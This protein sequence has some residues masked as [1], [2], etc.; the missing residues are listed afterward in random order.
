[1]RS[2]PPPPWGNGPQPHNEVAADPQRTLLRDKLALLHEEEQRLA[3]LSR[4]GSA[5]PIR[6]AK[7][8]TGSMKQKP[9]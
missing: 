4:D 6:L 9:S 1:M 5:P 3:S 2:R 8:L 7:L